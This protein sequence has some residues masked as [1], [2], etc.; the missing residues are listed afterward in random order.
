MH[1]MNLYVSVCVWF[2]CCLLFPIIHFAFALDQKRAI[3]LS[4]IFMFRIYRNA[5]Y[6]EWYGVPKKEEL[7][8]T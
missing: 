2:F 7:D 8:N 1:C 3:D 4:Y 5:K 6:H